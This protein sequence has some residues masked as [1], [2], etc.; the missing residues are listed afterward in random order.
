MNHEIS[1]L[2]KLLG[3]AGYAETPDGLLFPKEGLFARGEFI[4]FRNGVL[5][6]EVANLIV[7]EGRNYLLSAALKGGAAIS[8]WYVALFSGDVTPQATWTASNFAS[9]ATEFQNYS[10]A[11]RPAWEAGSVSSGVLDN[12]SEKAT[13]TISEDTQTVRGAAVISTASKG[14]TS[15]TLLGA[16][17]FTNAKSLDSDETLDIG[18]RVTITTPA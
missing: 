8:T 6:E 9:Q 1:E 12:Y 18:Y 4:V 17:K 11:T 5:D 16:A 7:T 14:G 3:C 10:E 15:G 13:F 2:S